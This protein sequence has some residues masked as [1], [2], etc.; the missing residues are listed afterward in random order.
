MELP[1][2]LKALPPEAL[3]V[4][5][6]FGNL[7]EPVAY[8]DD[9]ADGVGLSER[10]FG[11]V[12]RRL[13]TKGYLSMDGDQAYRLTDQGD[14]AVNELADYDAETP[15]DK[16]QRQAATAQQV[17]R[18]AVLVMPRALTVNTPTKVH[19]GIEP[20]R[21]SAGE[22]ADVVVRLSVMNG[23]PNRPQEASLD[24]SGDAA[25]REFE[26]TAGAYKQ[27]RLKVQVFQLGPNPDD[28]TVAG[29]MYVDADVTPALDPALARLVAYGTDLTFN[30]E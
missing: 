25:T 5:R 20:S 21:G 16:P 2:H 27:V 14:S 26:V 3:D 28:I 1:F 6:Y 19:I 13:V 24:L 30:Q 4:L 12:I 10:T 8:A 11:K 23:E 22:S 18:H 9:I 15:Q 7:D 17:R 29:G